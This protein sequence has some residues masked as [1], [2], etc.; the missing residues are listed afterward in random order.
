MFAA[1]GRGGGPDSAGFTGSEASFKRSTTQV[2]DVDR[3]RAARRPER[4]GPER[5]KGANPVRAVERRN[6]M[7]AVARPIPGGPLAQPRDRYGRA[8]DPGWEGKKGMEMKNWCLIGLCAEAMNLPLMLV[9]GQFAF[10]A[11]VHQVIF[12]SQPVCCG[13]N[14]RCSLKGVHTSNWMSICIRTLSIIFTLLWLVTRSHETAVGHASDCFLPTGGG[15]GS[16][17]ADDYWECSRREYYCGNACFDLAG[18][19]TAVWWSRKGF[20]TP[21]GVYEDEETRG[22]AKK[23]FEGFE[24]ESAVEEYYESRWDDAMAVSTGICVFC[25]IANS[26]MMVLNAKL[27]TLA[28]ATLQSQATVPVGVAPR[29]DYHQQ[30]AYPPVVMATAM[31]MAQDNGASAIEMKMMQSQMP[32]GVLPATQVIIMTPRTEED[33]H[34]SSGDNPLVARAL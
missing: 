11:C 6:E 16:G 2:L 3:Q 34:K 15:A 20:L 22:D 23:A 8:T 25:I 29:I 21:R 19:G 32:P 13:R 27:A 5:A 14:D 33:E 4:G 10:W 30:Q 9:F 31:P 1:A 7:A 28:S 17:A 12:L 26:L 18:N 24:S